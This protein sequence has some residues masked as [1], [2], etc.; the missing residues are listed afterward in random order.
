MKKVISLLLVLVLCLSLCGC[1]GGNDTPETKGNEETDNPTESKVETTE[2][3]EAGKDI[4][5]E[6]FSV[7]ST[8]EISLNFNADG[9][10]VHNQEGVETAF[11][12]K[13]D[14]ELNCYTIALGAVISATVE[15][16]DGIEQL[17]IGDSYCVRAEYYADAHKAYLA[18]QDAQQGNVWKDAILSE[19]EGKTLAQFNTSYNL[20]D[21]VEITIIDWEVGTHSIRGTDSAGIWLT[22]E[23]KNLTD[24]DIKRTE[25]PIVEGDMWVVHGASMSQGGCSFYEYFN[26]DDSGTLVSTFPANE[27]VKCLLNV[28]G[29]SYEDFDA[30]LN[31]FGYV[32][33][34][35]SFTFDG[36]EY[37]LD[38]ADIQIVK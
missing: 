14:E 25:L 13:Y 1:G 31:T 5:G 23:V 10:G 22:V 35:I 12:W 38:L 20:S 29:N 36:V 11:T 16:V 21:N 33:G 9:T 17:I 26:S 7:K 19:I 24:S 18:E 3:V 28:A 15:N 37:Y 32:L 34:F 8:T 30:S 2:A 4:L 27:T 6:W